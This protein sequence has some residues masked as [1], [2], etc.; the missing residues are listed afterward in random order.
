[1]NLSQSKILITGIGGFLGSHLA[2]ELSAK[3]A[4]LHGVIPWTQES[5]QNIYR[6][7]KADLT[8][9]DETQRIIREVRPDII[10]HLSS[11]ANGAPHM[12]L[13]LPILRNEVIASVNVLMASTDFGCSKL[14]M[15]GSLE[16]PLPEETPSSP[17]AAAK[18][19]SRSY[20]L[21]FHKL[22][23]T[24]IV[25]T[26]I[27]M[28]YGPGQPNWKVIPY[29]ALSLLRGEQP[30]IGSAGRMVDWVFVS[31]VVHGLIAIA[32]T[33]NLEGES[34]DLGSGTL[35]QIKDVVYKVRE[36]INPTIP[37]HFS[38]QSDRAFEQVRRADVEATFKKIQW[39]PR[40]SMERGLSLTVDSLKEMMFPGK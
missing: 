12:E 9:F 30:T 6:S 29:C 31:D 22:Y 20:G 3:G 15:A 5:S 2:R 38:P 10:Y 19:A 24:P 27:F 33:P 40:I 17:Y 26:R 21:M 18:A 16:E 35:V 14:I 23:G 1:M 7:W 11:L 25:F 39:R 32:C 36:L 37:I 28:T 8:R 4:E 13:V 34:L